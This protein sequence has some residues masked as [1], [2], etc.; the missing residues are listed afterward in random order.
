MARMGRRLAE[1]RHSL[2]KRPIDAALALGGRRRREISARPCDAVNCAAPAARRRR[3]LPDSAPP[4]CAGDGRWTLRGAKPLGHWL[5]L[6]ARG[7]SPL[8]VIGRKPPPPAVRAALV[9]PLGA[10]PM[11]GWKPG[12][13]GASTWQMAR[14]DAGEMAR[15]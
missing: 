5:A 1:S 6:A 9:A 11:G 15:I 8:A 13:G 10:P 4:P 14:A 7:A 2:C 12:P 3:A